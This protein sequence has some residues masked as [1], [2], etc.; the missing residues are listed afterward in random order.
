MIISKTPLRI[1]L[2]SGGS[3]IDA[4]Y[5]KEPGFALS[6]C[7]NRFVYVFCNYSSNL[8]LRALNYEIEEPSDVRD[9]RHA[10]TREGLLEFKQTTG[11]TVGQCSD[12]PPGG[13]GLGASSAYAVGLVN[14]LRRFSGAL[15]LDY[16]GAD[17]KLL[18]E[19][20]YMIE[21][22]CGY[23]VG[24]QDQYSAAYG[25]FN[26]F[27]FH[28][29]GVTRVWTA[30]RGVANY[31]S[32]G[33]TAWRLNDLESK[34]MLIYSGRSR[35][36][37]KVLEGYSSMSQKSREGA[38]VIAGMAHEAM[39]DITSGNFMN[40]GRLLHEAWQIKRD[41]HDGIT[42]PQLDAIYDRAYSAG[43]L[44]GKL[45]GAGGGGFFV[46]YV[47]EHEDRAKVMEAVMS[48]APGAFE[49]R[50]RFWDEGSTI[51]CV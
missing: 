33:E 10:I 3:D 1:S 50:F 22:K 13:S 6:G 47:Q 21:R 34:L 2:F 30:K 23:L 9:M 14:V 37:S 26:L 17:P 40:V 15:L 25:G 36:S 28:P 32:S 39:Y 42:D 43:A 38:R 46:F 49:E 19:K 27:S 12:I 51:Q 20:A 35:E 29:K 18:A 7:I 44:G 31:G 11:L 45:L 8:R 5:D 48:V 41:L 16:G 24:K 4:F